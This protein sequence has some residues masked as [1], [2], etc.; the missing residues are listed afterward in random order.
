MISIGQ[1]AYNPSL[2]AL[3]AEQD[4]DE[5]ELPR[6]KNDNQ[7]MIINSVPDKKGLFFQW[8]YFGI[9]IGSLLGVAIMSYIQDT[10]G[11]GLGF[12]VPTGVMV[13]ST[14]FF[15]CGSRF[16][17]Y[18]QGK[19]GGDGGGGG[20]GGGDDI[21]SCRSVVR[22]IRASAYKMMNAGFTLSNKSDVVEVE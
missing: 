21:K 19:G 2:Q 7:T 13:V 9:C 15:S 11:W 16:Y 20:G 12:A 10:V 4:E 5:D 22:A 1:A 6:S 17:T 18:R 3:G 8:W 14:A